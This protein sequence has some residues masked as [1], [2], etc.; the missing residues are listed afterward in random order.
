M[1]RLCGPG[2]RAAAPRSSYRTDG[3][4]NVGAAPVKAI[5]A[6]AI[7]AACLMTAAAAHHTTQHS[8]GPCG[9]ADCA[10]KHKGW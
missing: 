4:R 7:L 8:I 6:S 5:L 10:G 2:T 1:P 9:Q 3:D